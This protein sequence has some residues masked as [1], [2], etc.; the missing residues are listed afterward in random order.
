MKLLNLLLN[1]MGL[2]LLATFPVLANAE[3]CADGNV[4]TKETRCGY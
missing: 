4:I 1:I 3:N 2:L